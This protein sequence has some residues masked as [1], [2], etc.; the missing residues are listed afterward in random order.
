MTLSITT[1][2]ITTLSITSLSIMTISIMTLSITTLSI[3]TH[4]ITIRKFDTQL[5]GNR[6]LLPSVVMLSVTII[7]TK[8]MAPTVLKNFLWP[9]L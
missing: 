8:I 2:S 5:N 6:M 7:L 4:S 9:Y 3:T 1:L